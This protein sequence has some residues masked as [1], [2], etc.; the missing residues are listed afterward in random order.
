MIYLDTSAL[1]KLVVEEDESAVLTAWLGHDHPNEALVASDL[2]RVEL[3]RSIARRE[4]PAGSA[5]DAQAL[6]DT[7]DMIPLTEAVIEL[8]E[9]IGPPNLRSVDA[10]H[11]AAAAQL[12]TELTAFVAYDT[13]LFDA[14]AELR[15]PATA[16]GNPTAPPRHR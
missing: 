16:P 7:L 8:A 11:L 5:D 3:M 13:R 1:V 9:S 2:A 15:M 4:L 10:I 6:L 12:G 14:D